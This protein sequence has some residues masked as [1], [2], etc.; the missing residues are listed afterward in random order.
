VREFDEVRKEEIKTSFR[1]YPELCATSM[2]A[3]LRIVKGTEGGLDWNNDDTKR[4][5]EQGDEVNIRFDIFGGAHSTQAML[6]LSIEKPD[7]HRYKVRSANV[8]KAETPD[9]IML[10]IGT[11]QNRGVTQVDTFAGSFESCI[12]MAEAS[13]LSFVILF[14]STVC[15]LSPAMASYG[16]QAEGEAIFKRLHQRIDQDDDHRPACTSGERN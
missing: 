3:L 16:R 9:V 14:C 11:I 5:L 4:N 6:E 15:R 12:K 10:R 8:Y 2:N 7:E 1:L 13:Y